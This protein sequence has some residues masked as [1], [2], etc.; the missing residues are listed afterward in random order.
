MNGGAK[1]VALSEVPLDKN[2]ERPVR[3]EQRGGCGPLLE[4]IELIRHDVINNDKENRKAELFCLPPLLEA[5]YFA[6]IL[7]FAG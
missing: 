1:G 3:L 4:K 5:D 6:L 2:E 7:K